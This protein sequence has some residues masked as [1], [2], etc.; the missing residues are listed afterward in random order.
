MF[1][2]QSIVSHRLKGAI[3]LSCIVS[4]LLLLLACNSPRQTTQDTSQPVPDSISSDSLGNPYFNQVDNAKYITSDKLQQCYTISKSNELVKY[5]AKGTALFRFNNNR[6]GELIWVD[7]TDPFNLL[8]YYPEYMTLITLDRTLGMTGEFQLYDMDIAEVTAVAM[9]NDNNIWLH[10]QTRARI[11]KINKQGSILNE[12]GNLNLLF[13]NISPPNFMLEH[14]NLLYVN[15]PDR[16]I[17]VFDNFATYLKTIPIKNLERFQIIDK[18]LIFEEGNAVNSFHLQSLLAHSLKL[19]FSYKQGD[20]LRIQK[21]VL[22]VLKN[23]RL[24]FYQL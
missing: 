20:Q 13:E 6:L 9:T 12:S 10:D 7:A 4:A 22:F 8:L 18:Q 14:D 16:G 17:L 2:Q 21:D 3:H 11:V 19:P 1:R 5:N 23:G 15:I 24:L